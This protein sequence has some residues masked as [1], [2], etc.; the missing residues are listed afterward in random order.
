MDDILAL[1]FRAIPA[2]GT[3]ND[4][5]V[6]AMAA[7]GEDLLAAELIVEAQ[8]LCVPLD[9]EFR[10]EQFRYAIGL[11]QMRIA[12]ADDRIDADVLIFPEA[13]SNRLRRA[14]E[15]S[16]RTGAHQTD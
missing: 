7:A 14:D 6:A 12:G 2:S 1:W 16:T 3:G 10:E 11:L 5:Q 4:L 15:R 8:A 9:A 13:R